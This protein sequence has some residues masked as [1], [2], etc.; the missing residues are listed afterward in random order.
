M[1]RELFS[2]NS[3]CQDSLL[4]ITDPLKVHFGIDIFWYGCLKENGDFIN[5]CNRPEMYEYGW[6]Q[7]CYKLVPYL[8]N[9]ARLESGSLYV[10]CDGQYRKALDKLEERLLP[11]HS[12]VRIRKDAQGRACFF[13]FASTKDIPSLPAFYCNNQPI[14]NK[15]VD[16]FLESSVV[17]HA[18][19]AV[20]NLAKLKGEELFFGKALPSIQNIR[21]LEEIGV[22]PLLLKNAHKLSS[23]EK[24][25]LLGH[26]ERKNSTQLAEEF[27]IT[28]RTVQFYLANAKNKL[29]I[30]SRAELDKA[31]D[32]LKIAGFLK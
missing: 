2:N 14:L 19:K 3:R 24:E 29:G 30:I 6:E 7:N 22:D 5:I 31:V 20:I 28:F 27:G 9:P 18:S 25:V 23:R 4:K 26:Y 12:L 8:I 13:G 17:T 10:Q 32:I 16:Y 11:Y 21:F 15:Y 1:Y